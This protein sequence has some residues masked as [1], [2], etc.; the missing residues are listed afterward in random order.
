MTEGSVEQPTK[1]DWGRAEWAS[2]SLRNWKS[3][4]PSIRLVKDVALSARRG[5]RR[6]LTDDILKAG[7]AFDTEVVAEGVE[8]IPNSGGAILAMSHVAAV[9]EFPGWGKGRDNLL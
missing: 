1:L 3:L 6:S 2:Y 9:K 8:N 5:E 7:E 4:L